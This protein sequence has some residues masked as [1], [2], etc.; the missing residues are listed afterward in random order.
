M[1]RR[2]RTKKGRADYAER[3][4]IVEPVFGQMKIQDRR[5]GS[6]VYTAPRGSP[7]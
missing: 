5:P 6:F 2:L 4:A 7:R 3:E 1:A